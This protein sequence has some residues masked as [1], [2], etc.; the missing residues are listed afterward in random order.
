MP[1]RCL[2]GNSLNVVQEPFSVCE[3]ELAKHHRTFHQMLPD[4]LRRQLAEQVLCHNFW[5]R[6]KM[7]TT[8]PGFYQH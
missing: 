2:S 7:K 3:G 6:L 1:K 8:A 4:Q 5:L